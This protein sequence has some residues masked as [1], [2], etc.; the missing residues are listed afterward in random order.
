MSASVASA[1]NVILQADSD[2][3]GSGEILFQVSGS[4]PVTINNDGNV[5]IA[6][7][8]PNARLEVADGQILA[9]VGN[10]TTPGIGF[11]GDSDTG[12]FR[13]T[14][15][16]LNF[17]IDGT[18]KATLSSAGLSLYSGTGIFNRQGTESAPSYTF[19][20]DISQD[21][22][23]FLA[24]Q[25]NIG[26]TTGGSEK[27]R[28]DGNGNIGI[29]TTSP[30]QALSVSGSS[31]I[32][33][34]LVLAGEGSEVYTLDVS[35][36]VRANSYIG[37]GSQL[38]GITAG[39][40][41][42]AS[43]AVFNS[44][45][46]SS[47]SDGG[48]TF[49]VES[50]PVF[51]I[52]D[53]GKVSV[54]SGAATTA[55]FEVNAD[56]G[57]AA[58][59]NL[60]DNTSSNFVVSQDGNDYINI[61]TTDGS[62]TITF[63]NSTTNQNNI[64]YGNVGIGTANPAYPL[65]VKSLS[66]GLAVIAAEASNSTN[67]LG[68]FYE[69]GGNHGGL[70]LRDNTNTDLV[71]IRTDGATFFNGG[72]VGIGVSAPTNALQVSGTIVADNF[73][74][75]GSGLTNISVGATGVSGAIQLSDGAGNLET[76]NNLYWDGSSK[77]GI[78]SS[79]PDGE[80][81]V[82]SS[83]P[84]EITIEGDS[85]GF[86]NGAVVMKANNGTNYRALGTYMH[87]AGGDTEWFTGRPYADSDRYVISRVT[88]VASHDNSAAAISSA[89]LV[90]DD[91]GN[92]GV[93]VTA[94]TEALHVSGSILST[95]LAGGGTQCVQVDNSG[96]LSATGSAC[97][98]GSGGTPTSVSGAIQLSDGSGNFVEDSN[99]TWDQANARLG[100]GTTNPGTPLVVVG[101]GQATAT[102]SSNDSV[103]TS[104]VINNSDS[105]KSW[106]LGV[107][108]GT[109]DGNFPV[110]SFNIHEPGVKTHFSVAA[111][112]NITI[113]SL[114]G[115]GTSC[116]QVDNSGVLSATG[117]ACGSGGG[118]GSFEADG[119]VAMSGALVGNSATG[120]A[121][122]T[123][124][125]DTNTGIG[126]SAA[127]TIDLYANGNSILSVGNS[128]ITATQN[129]Q[130][131]GEIIATASGANSGVIRAD[132]GSL[133][134]PTLHNNDGEGVL[135]DAG[136]D[137][138]TL[139]TNQSAA[140]TVDATQ[141]VGIRTSSPEGIVHIAWG[142]SDGLVLGADSG[143]SSITNSTEKQFRMTSPHY[144][145][146]EENVQVMFM[147]NTVSTNLLNIG[148]GSFN[149]NSINELRFF[150]A[151][152]NTTVQ[153][154][155]RM[156][157]DSDGEV[158]IGVLAPTNALQ[159]SGTIVA[160]NFSGDGS[161][162][163][164]VNVDAKGVSGAIQL[165]DGNGNLV[166]DDELFYNGT[167]F[168][169][170]TNNPSSKFHIVDGLNGSTSGLTVEN[171]GTGSSAR[172]L[173]E[174]K[175]Q[176]GG[177]L[178]LGSVGGGN[179]GSPYGANN[180]FM[181][182]FAKEMSI[183]NYNGGAGGAIR[184][185]MGGQTNSDERMRITNG[186][187]IAIGTVT[188]DVALTVASGALCVGNDA[189]CA[190]NSNIE[191][192]IHAAEL[193]DETGA[194]CSTISQ[195]SSAIASSSAVG[196]SGAIQLSNGA[197]GLVSDS[198]L[199]WD[200]ANSRLGVGSAS[201]ATGLHISKSNGTESSIT[202]ENTGAAPNLSSILFRSEGFEYSQIRGYSADSNSGFL[203]FYVSDSGA[204]SE[205]MRI[206]SDGQVGIGTMSPTESLDV[207]GTVKADFFSGDGSGLTNVNVGATG[208]SGAIQLSNGAGGLVSDS[209]LFWD[210]NNSRLGIG[211][212][213]PSNVL[214]VKDDNNN[215]VQVEIE[216]TGTAAGG[217][218]GIRFD[219]SSTLGSSIGHAGSGFAHSNFTGIGANNA[220]WF[221][222]AEMNIMA[223]GSAVNRGISFT[224][225]GSTPS[226]EKMYINVN[227]VAIGTNDTDV[228]LTVAS[229]ALCVGNT[230]DC[231]GNS[232]TEGQIHAV[233][234]C[235]ETGANCS[236]ISQISSAIASASSVAAKGVSN[237]I[238][239]S[240]GSGGFVSDDKFFYGGS[241]AD[242]S[243]QFGFG[244]SSPSGLATFYA[245]GK[246]TAS[247][248]NF[249]NNYN[250]PSAA[251]GIDMKADSFA[252]LRMGM[253]SSGYAN[254]LFPFLNPSEGYIH[255]QSNL[256]I[257]AGTASP[258]TGIF[259]HTPAN[260]WSESMRISA[261]GKVAI[262]TAT[263]DVALTI[264][265]GAL[266]VGNDTI[267]AGNSNTEGQIHAAEL[268]D[269]TG[270]NC[271]DLSAGLAGGAVSVSGAIQLSDGAGGF[272][273]DGNLFWDESAEELG[274]GTS[275]P[276]HLLDLQDNE[277]SFLTM[278][279]ENTSTAGQAGAGINFDSSSSVDSQLFHTGSGFAHTSFPAIGAG[280]AVWTAAGKVNISSRNAG[281][282][283][284][285]A[286]FAGG[287]P[288][289]TTE[290]MRINVNGVGIGTTNPAQELE[291]NGDVLATS[292]LY[293]SD[294][295]LKTNIEKILG[296][297]LIMLLKGVR[298]EWK[299]DGRQDIGFIAQD[300]EKV[301]PELVFTDPVTGMKSVQYGNIVAPL[302]EAVKEVNEKVDDNARA[303]AS[304]E[305]RNKELEAKNKELEA[306]LER[307][308]KALLK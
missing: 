264:A 297:D 270:A 58:N 204:L 75:D 198:S 57:A 19:T 99:L 268:C 168:G 77:L 22:G 222:N 239:L 275:N 211:E 15:G 9:P 119:S 280:E 145:N 195:I 288:S 187:G 1:A 46:D 258:T 171:T 146:A 104:M 307:L 64:F 117:S 246:T 21:T 152:D 274:L 277:N 80:L 2:A 116:V 278:E 293:S 123:F 262:G 234:L 25:N 173:I 154:T 67:L 164:N 153:G 13:R 59:I 7:G 202:L 223:Y 233:E 184:F 40:T 31:Y 174:L 26:F 62:E 261:E 155:E 95:D 269:E 200:Q 221:S 137:S 144:L 256:K 56:S 235:D 301:L 16:E 63:G 32:S 72:N 180:V 49:Q 10:A 81:H 94:P 199:F 3:N 101:T 108:G 157:I 82:Y 44:D 133:L 302:V 282:T 300:V 45:A 163:T 148:G 136:T 248:V 150:T 76:S 170:G 207:S 304:L 219:S 110:N 50:L 172:G 226:D 257:G 69:N 287:I 201:P 206:D 6:T 279:I 156:I 194:N 33:G 218:A 178:T 4:T 169:F 12:L 285:I 34:G 84:T 65:E 91:T 131:F 306:R 243:R 53:D 291:V 272:V 245:A 253:T 176:G 30:S 92:V 260:D 229:G 52:A 159:V 292:Y 90:V 37:D 126:R 113:D 38:T 298:F 55:A 27:M 89:L 43:A 97:G 124:D 122:Y 205:A 267:C 79:S 244:T 87:D 190:G 193:C 305:A 215:F 308:E 73:S 85:T 276:G 181:E 109:G 209:S 105:G 210:E 14:P 161:G 165:S 142:S 61:D 5:G 203:N 138:L 230:G 68:F 263:A 183:T 177:V 196:V 129:M 135:L 286:F 271:S 149:H 238:Q 225:G 130:V 266:C 36:T 102:I 112:G 240:D 208:V 128:E 11:S 247:L 166:T 237:A 283:S 20:D 140:L 191:G 252:R 143:T 139:V 107:G 121:Q 111:G 220:F 299:K 189:D 71:S 125:G 250:H 175:S 42:A 303:I 100:I 241:E 114:A 289:T 18:W 162:L 103:F 141:R 254:S 47:G 151:A 39:A 86:H 24:G 28:I 132:G 255:S 41:T 48:F 78:G 179:T 35:G 236:T 182:T 127:N 212:S 294:E 167:R 231:S 17:A 93:G 295:R 281:A 88:G 227:G 249:E 188:A 115:S 54:G 98:S 185:L 265:S 284:G 251:G 83:G 228:A 147:N 296:L 158:G 216:S 8:T 66:A 186:G 106:H 29:G 232:N 120:S 259:F 74:G 273:T 197:G 242:W 160:D 217:G 96:V 192:Q 51:S 23:L 118:S 60:V 290:K 213:S 224:A 70:I 134:V 214:H